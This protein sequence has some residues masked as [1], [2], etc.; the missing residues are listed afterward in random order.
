MCVCVSNTYKLALCEALSEEDTCRPH[1]VVQHV[2]VLNQSAQ[3]LIE[4]SLLLVISVHLTCTTQAPQH[5]GR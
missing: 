5:G 4:L 3:G 2:A 1:Q